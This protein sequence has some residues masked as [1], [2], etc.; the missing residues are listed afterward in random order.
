MISSSSISILFRGFRVTPI[1]QVALVNPSFVVCVERDIPT[2]LPHEKENPRQVQAI[3]QRTFEEP[4]P[5]SCE[6]A[7][8]LSR[9]TNELDI[10]ARVE[11]WTPTVDGPKASQCGMFL[12]STGETDN[13]L[14][15]S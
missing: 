7:F 10:K 13:L 15:T 14:D 8:Q 11:G 5:A 1:D 6:C 2:A 4:P 9:I 12:H 3:H